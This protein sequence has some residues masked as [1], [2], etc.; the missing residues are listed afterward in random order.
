[1]TARNAGNPDRTWHRPLLGWYR[2]QRRDLPWRRTRDPYAILVSE[3]MLQQTR[4]AV[5]EERWRRFLERFP[6]VEA[7]AAAPE[8][9]VVALWSGL[10]YYRRARNLHAAARAVRDRHGGR[11]PDEFERLRELP[12]VGA[13]TAAAVAS[14]AFDRPA[15]LVDGNVARVLSRWFRL[16]GEP[17][18]T[19]AARRLRE[20]AAELIPQDGTAGEWNQALMELGALIC[21]PR[22]P[23]CDECPVASSCGAASEGRP[24]RYPG[25]GRT[26]RTVRESVVRVALE[27]RG[28]WLM[29]RNGADEAPAGLFEF[30]ALTGAPKYWTAAAAARLVERAW[31]MRVVACR[32]PGTIRHQILERSITVRVWAAR[33]AAGPAVPPRSAGRFRWVALSRLSE[34][35]VSG[36]ALKIGKLLA[37]SGP[38]RPARP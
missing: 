29:R 8:D 2:R 22:G 11:V 19:A 35:P 27:R 6:T 30:P 15:P 32:E 24:E 26:P 18:E 14:I 7:L 33:V 23:R 9:E 4:V 38:D 21:V 34:L 37:T 28:R 1:M 10:G 16:R 31:G 3:F 12:G 5:V 17:R 20:L 13:Y 25:R 36:A